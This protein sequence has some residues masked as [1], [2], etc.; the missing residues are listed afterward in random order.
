[1]G[2]VGVS[3]EL[4]AHPNAHEAA[5]TRALPERLDGCWSNEARIGHFSGVRGRFRSFNHFGSVFVL[6]GEGQ[7]QH[8]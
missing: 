1:M 5:A 7:E 2:G 8:P 6:E 3:N 4:G